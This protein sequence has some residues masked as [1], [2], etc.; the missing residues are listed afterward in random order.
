MAL[1][2]SPS[3]EQGPAERWVSFDDETKVL[4]RSLDDDSY[5]IGLA[6]ARRQINKA[7]AKFKTGDVGVAEGE[8]TEHAYQ[9]KLLSRYILKGWQG[10]KDASGVD[11]KY[12]PEAG[13]ATL[14][15]NIDFF[16][17]V[18]K[19]ASGIAS[20]TAKEQADTVGKS[21]PATDGSSSANG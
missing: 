18:I 10:A 7:D 8:I 13:E 5:Q 1:V 14:L 19:E 3:V 11:V 17:F 6:R 20:D 9:C 15:A 21:S 4:L 16:L 2:V 12:T